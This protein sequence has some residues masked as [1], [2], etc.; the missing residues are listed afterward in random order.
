MQDI[1]F[2]ELTNEE[3]KL[4][5]DILDFEINKE[6]IIF[7]KGTGK[8]YICPI[9]EERVHFKNASILPGSTVIINTSA[10][11]LAEYFSKFLEKE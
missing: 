7:E 11:T 10:L 5:L 9:T 1:T 2:V 6:G 8:P 3:K 4:L